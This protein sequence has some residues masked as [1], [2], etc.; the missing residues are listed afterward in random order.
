MRTTEN[1]C[2][3]ALGMCKKN[4][5]SKTGNLNNVLTKGVVTKKLERLLKE[6]PPKD[7]ALIQFKYFI[8]N[9][10]NIQVLILPDHRQAIFQLIVNTVR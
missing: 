10:E 9:F 8:D 5:V 2:H 4:Y 1:I 7:Y 3:I 6:Y